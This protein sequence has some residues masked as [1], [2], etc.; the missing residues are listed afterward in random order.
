MKEEKAISDLAVFV[1]QNKTDVISLINRLRIASLPL[2]ASIA[3]VNEVVID[4]SSN[5]Q[6]ESG[7]QKIAT[8]G[9]NSFICA[10]ICI[11]IAVGVIAITTTVAVAS[12][13]RR[14]KKMREDIFRTGFRSRYLNKETLNEIAFIERKKMQNKFLLAQSDYLQQEENMIQ[15]NR[16]KTKM[17]SLYIVLGGALAVLI[18]I[19]L[20][21]K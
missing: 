16:E 14:N 3:N 2:N 17:N 10:G 4:N 5:K 19:K 11:A 20:L 1:L 15:K 6:L 18:A 21:K 13:I 12:D 7:L 8:K 9:Y